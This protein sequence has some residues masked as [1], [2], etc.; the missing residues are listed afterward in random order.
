MNVNI[1]TR[2]FNSVQRFDLIGYLSSTHQIKYSV[3]TYIYTDLSHIHRYKYIN[4]ILIFFVGW[5]GRDQDG[6]GT[7]HPR[8]SGREQ[9]YRPSTLRFILEG[10]KVS[11]V[12]IHLLSLIFHKHASRLRASST[13][14]T[15][16]SDSLCVLLLKCSA[17]SVSSVLRCAVSFWWPLI[18]IWR[19]WPVSPTYWRPQLLHVIK[20]ITLEDLQEAKNFTLNTFPVVWLENSSVIIRMGQGL[21]LDTPHG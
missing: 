1:T 6:G 20:Y 4:K 21:H 19:N 5:L 18:L 11:R 15:A 7:E 8:V 13:A 14:R 9:I 17:T 2:Y 3:N 12:L 10:D 16:M